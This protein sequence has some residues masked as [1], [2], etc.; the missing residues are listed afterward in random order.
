[1]RLENRGGLALSFILTTNHLNK[2]EDD[3]SGHG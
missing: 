1:M 2:G 3:Q